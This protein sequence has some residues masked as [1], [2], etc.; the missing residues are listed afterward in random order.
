MLPSF[1]TQSTG[2][3]KYVAP[4][5]AASNLLLG[6]HLLYIMGC[7]CRCFQKDKSMLLGKLLSLLCAHR[8][9][10]LHVYTPISCP[11]GA[12]IAHECSKRRAAFQAAHQS[13]MNQLVW[14]SEGAYRKVALVANKHDGHIGVSMLPCVFQPAG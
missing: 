13:D 1:S 12:T 6:A 4:A 3:S 10:M 14:K 7:L 8:T 9:P 2:V 5:Q 11:F